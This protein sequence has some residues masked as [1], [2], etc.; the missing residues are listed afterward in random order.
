MNRLSNPYKYIPQLLGVMNEEFIYKII[1]DYGKENQGI[2][3]IE[4]LAEL[5][6]EIICAARGEKN[7]AALAEEISH[8]MISLCIYG[9]ANHLNWNMNS[10]LN[11]H[12]YSV[13]EC[14]LTLA[15][16]QKEISKKTR[17]KNNDEILCSKMEKCLVYL[18]KCMKEY[19]IT[20]DMIT[21]E[22]NK[23]IS[24]YTPTKKSNKP[25][26]EINLTPSDVTKIIANHLCNEGYSIN[27]DKIDF[28][29]DMDRDGEHECPIFE[30]CSIYPQYEHEEERQ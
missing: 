11:V 22:V 4:E 13:S 27:E 25:T 30:G 1:N 21:D 28:N 15:N 6:I 14:L 5:E 24:K 23:K 7:K 9:Q 10:N 16:L 12:M 3:L 17:G 8:C 19:N 26:R 18:Q 20:W 2:V 29:V